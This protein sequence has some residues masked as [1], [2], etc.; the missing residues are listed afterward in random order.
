[1][2]SRNLRIVY[3]MQQRVN[4]LSFLLSSF[5]LSMNCFPSVNAGTIYRSK[6][7]KRLRIT[8]RIRAIHASS[9][10]KI[11]THLNV[12]SNAQ[13]PCFSTLTP[14]SCNQSH[15]P[16]VPTWTVNLW[17][18][19]V[20]YITLIKLTPH[21]KHS[22]FIKRRIGQYCW[23]NTTQTQRIIRNTYTCTSMVH[24]VTTLL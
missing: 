19:K 2:S 11:R 23:V 9:Q 18:S 8:T 22:G 15:F 10:I 6:C 17:S 16:P 3:S 1:M 24:I 7:A 21:K 5:F 4:S 13:S 14:V 12:T 20:V